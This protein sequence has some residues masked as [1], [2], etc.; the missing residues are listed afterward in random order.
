MLPFFLFSF[1]SDPS[2]ELILSLFASDTILINDD[3]GFWVLVKAKTSF[4]QNKIEGQAWI[5]NLGLDCLEHPR[6]GGSSR[7]SR[8]LTFG[9][10]LTRLL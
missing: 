4:L 8:G 2:A 3:S 9:S 7:C 10:F 5:C 1:L 6:I